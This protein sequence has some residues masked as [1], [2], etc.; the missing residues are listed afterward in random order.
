MSTPIHRNGLDT[1]IVYQGTN[2]VRKLYRGHVVLFDV[3]SI[4][5]GSGPTEPPVEPDLNIVNPLIGKT[6]FAQAD[7][8]TDET[9]QLNVSIIFKTNGAITST[10]T[11]NNIN[12]L[13]NERFTAS[14]L[15]NS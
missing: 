9:S 7:T 6:V 4:I 11:G 10:I 13:G 8:F 14:W 3:G 5:D 12:L 2:R 1:V 15:I